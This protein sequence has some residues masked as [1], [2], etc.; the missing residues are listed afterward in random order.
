MHEQQRTTLLQRTAFVFV[1]SIGLALCLLG[2]Q[3]PPHYGPDQEPSVGRALAH[4][5]GDLNPNFF[6][7]P[8]FYPY[9]VASVYWILGTIADYPGPIASASATDTYFFIARYVT[10]FTSFVTIVLTYLIGRRID[11]P[12]CGIVAALLLSL[13]SLNI[14]NGHFA[15]VDVP[16]TCFMVVAAYGAFRVL[17]DARFRWRWCVASAMAA[18]LAA[19]TK[20]PAGIAIFLP[21]LAVS[22]FARAQQGGTFGMLG[23]R[24]YWAAILAIGLCSFATFIGSSPYILSEFPSF[25]KDLLFEIEHARKGH[26]GFDTAPDGFQYTRGVYL[27]VAGLPFSL[28]LPFYLL[29]LA[30]LG[31][32]SYRRDPADKLALAFI[33]VFYLITGFGKT[34]KLNYLVPLSPFLALAAARVVAAGLRS[35][36]PKMRAATQTVVATVVLYTAVYGWTTARQFVTD[37]RVRAAGELK[38]LFP[39]QGTTIALPGSSNYF[40]KLDRAHFKVKRCRKGR[41][42]VRKLIACNTDVMMVSSMLHSRSLRDPD[43]HPGRFSAY[44]KLLSGATP[45]EQV[46]VFENE[47]LNK[48]LYMRLDPMF[49]SY[50]FAPT[51]IVFRKKQRSTA[52]TPPGSSP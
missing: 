49:E 36:R 44:Q 4:L 32:A 42:D 47:F 50:R 25:T 45:Y 22:L 26:Y 17:L 10:V 24:R 14:R 29:S 46:A 38:H 51:I 19:G 31:L 7:Y 48:E 30:G 28:G 13:T 41:F 35:G 2:I 15:N 3:F 16:S 6:R 37:P 20:Y 12:W 43:L 52:D 1:L 21:L 9:L 8:S 34:V 40:P 11:G 39:Q 27:L 18:G 5:R 23:A 33:I